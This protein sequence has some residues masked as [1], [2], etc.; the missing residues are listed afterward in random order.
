[1]KNLKKLSRVDLKTLAGGIT[2]RKWKCC[3]VG[4]G[5]SGT[6]TGDFSVCNKN[7]GIV[8]YA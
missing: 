2:G 5:C 4:G 8:V 7:G 1:M 3:V 6:Q